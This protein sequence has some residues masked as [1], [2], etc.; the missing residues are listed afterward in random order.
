MYHLL[1]IHSLSKPSTSANPPVKEEQVE[2]M[3]CDQKP[4]CLPIEIK[5]NPS[6]SQI[7]KREKVVKDDSSSEQDDTAQ[8]TMAENTTKVTSK[9]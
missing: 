7:T 3:D 4:T 9:R 5:C 2:E 6:D 1:S 8:G